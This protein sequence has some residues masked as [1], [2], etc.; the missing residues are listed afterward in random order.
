MKKFFLIFT[1]LF[2]LVPTAS[3][4]FIESFDSDIY[5][6]DA[7]TMR[8]N[9]T[10]VYDF[11]NEWRHGIFRDIPG[12][13]EFISVV[14]ENN[15]PYSYTT[16]G[17]YSGH[18]AKIGDPNVTITGAHTYRITYQTKNELGFFRD[19]DELYWNVNGKDWAIPILNSSAT[20]TFPFEFKKTDPQL[21]ATCYTGYYKKPDSDCSYT[22]SSENQITTFKF[23]TTKPL[24]STTYSNED[25]TIV[26]GIPKTFLDQPIQWVPWADRQWGAHS[27]TFWGK[28]APQIPITFIA[29]LIFLWTYKTWKKKGDDPSPLTPVVAQYAPPNNLPAAELNVLRFN[30]LTPKALTATIFEL[31][32]KGI[33]T[34][35]ENEKKSLTFF[36][37][38]YPKNNELSEFQQYV[39]D[40]IFS[41]GDRTEVKLSKLKYQLSGFTLYQKKIIDRLIKDGYYQTRPLTF[42]KFIFIPLGIVSIIIGLIFPLENYWFASITLLIAGFTSLITGIFMTKKTQPGVELTQQIK[43]FEKFLQVTEKERLAFHNPPNKTIELFEAML[44]FAVALKVEKNW[45]KSFQS[46]IEKTPSANV[47]SWLNVQKFDVSHITKTFR[48]IESIGHIQSSS[49]GSGFSG[50]SS[51]GGGGGGGGGSW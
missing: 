30:K 38:R 45:V 51:G 4:E 28:N 12:D 21:R 2:A 47:Y 31:G 22:I 43:G 20:V 25:M 36:L 8:I 41:K 5:I 10:I 39:Y 44:P 29:F 6:V 23:E 26:A 14:D 35:N 9:E 19:H 32:I 34:I 24:E 7:E 11:G 46:L 33:L 37:K 16:S 18:E 49:R 13:I 40:K 48:S 1:L 17:D 27:K 42:Y 15:I 50:G 3:A